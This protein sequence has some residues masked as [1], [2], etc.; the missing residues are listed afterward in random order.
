MDFLESTEKPPNTEKDLLLTRNNLEIATQETKS[1]ALQVQLKS[2]QYTIEAK[3]ETFFQHW[4]LNQVTSKQREQV[5]WFLGHSLSTHFQE[6]N[7]RPVTLR[8][9]RR[10][11]KTSTNWKMFAYQFG[12]D[13]AK[14][15]LIWNQKT[16][17]EFRKGIEDEMRLLQHEQDLIQQKDTLVSWNHT[18]F[19][20]NYPS[21][22]EEI[23]IGDYYLRFLLNEDSDAATPIHDPLHFF[24]NV[25]HRFLLSTRTDM[26]CLCLR[27][28][29]IA[30][31]RHFMTIGSF[32]DS[33]YIVQML[34]GKYI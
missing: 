20:V 13:H 22:Q 31:G 10:H 4:N 12:Q 25:Y 9:R 27:A 15:D 32:S 18:E 2:M 29:G 7:Q 8:K 23:K 19:S 3:M 24:N 30:Y 33:K 34:R 21:V 26:K 6:K 5:I 16:R 17:E 14:A 1:S 28:M 11:I